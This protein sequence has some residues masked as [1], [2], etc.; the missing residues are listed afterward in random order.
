MFGNA[1]G[2]ARKEGRILKVGPNGVIMESLA[3]SN[4][5]QS[6]F[7]SYDQL[8]SKGRGIAYELYESAKNEQKIQSRRDYRALRERTSRMFPM[9]TTDEQFNAMNN[10]MSD[11][12][13]RE[14]YKRIA[15]KQEATRQAEKD[16]AA[17]ARRNAIVEKADS[18]M[19]PAMFNNDPDTIL[20]NKNTYLQHRMCTD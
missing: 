11:Q 10:S 6:G 8:D 20:A 5:G 14:T 16:A 19:S 1:A 3:G 17:K 12:E 7:I 4:R 18:I 9:G 2:T 15:E 13:L